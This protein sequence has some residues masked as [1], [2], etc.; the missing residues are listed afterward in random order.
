M[1][2]IFMYHV[3][4]I[5][6]NCNH[7]RLTNCREIMRLSFNLKFY[8]TVLMKLRKYINKSHKEKG[9]QLSV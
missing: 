1:Q 9:E 7:E 4:L 5:L 6:D 8:I 3:M 2:F